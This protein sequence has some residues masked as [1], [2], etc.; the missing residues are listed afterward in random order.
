MKILKLTYSEILKQTKKL[1]FK[2]CL[3]I[4]LAFAIG[5]PV[6]FK[7][8]S[9]DEYSNRIY[10]EE[11][12]SYY[13]NSVMENPKTDEEQLENKLNEVMIDIIKMSFAKEKN[14]EATD[15]KT[16]LYDEYRN[17]KMTAVVLEYMIEGKTIDYVK[18][19]E[20]FNLNSE[21]YKGIELAELSEIR[22]NLLLKAEETV[23]IID[24][25]DYTYYLNEQ[26]ENL[27][28]SESS[29]VNDNLIKVYE[30]LIQLNITDESDFR[31]NEANS[32]IENYNQKEI[33]MTKHEYKDQKS[34]ISYDD[35]LKL[36][37]IKNKELD[38]SIAKSWYAIEHNINY[39]KEGAKSAFNDSI[40]NNT[41]FLS[42]IIVI[43]AGGI[44]ANEFQK[45][46]IRLLVI[47][48]NK[49]WKILLS[50]FLAIISI[51]IVLALI[52]YIASFVTNGL[53]FGFKD[54]F[55]PDLAVK[56]ASVA[57]VSY[58]LNSI[59]KLGILLIPI[60]FVGLIAFALSAITKN[61]AL[62][63]GVSIFLLVGYSLI[64]MMMVLIEMPFID[65][66]FLPYLEYVQFTDPLSL[67]NS[68]Y[69]YDIYY[70]FK[71]A[72]IVLLIWAILIYALTNYIFIKRDI[73]N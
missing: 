68:C 50:K 22:D 56:G 20:E 48:P 54:Y 67:V 65:L 21:S 12:L 47:R 73:K 31:I 51:I 37:S 10:Y 16:S 11:D 35:Y 26:L 71:Q 17:Y 66:T 30:K 61:T 43:I 69:S 55:I 25:N 27:K 33:P 32:I 14:K 23:K 13:E 59:I 52:T 40:Q 3:I 42:I 39:N 1:S 70:T 18:I 19:D 28:N 44:V 62:S 5:I 49:R 2:V 72:N 4:L 15:F 24:K 38:D 36:T 6:L 34:K 57:E 63:V 58:I 41:V 46:T 53:L 7:A 9:Q 60:V 29:E 8:L 45:G 64:I